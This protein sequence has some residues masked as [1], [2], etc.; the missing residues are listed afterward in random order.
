MDEQGLIKIWNK[1]RSQIITAQIAPAL[2]LIGIF[3][4]A[5]QGAFNDAG[6]AAKFLSISTAAITGLLAMISQYAAIREGQ[7]LI[8]DLQKVNSSSAL[9][10]KI[11]DSYEYL[12]IMLYVVIAFGVGSFSLVVWSVLG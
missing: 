6:D 11:V 8:Q 9:S 3:V 7:A 4:L 12:N 2:V 5:N 1:N 10:K